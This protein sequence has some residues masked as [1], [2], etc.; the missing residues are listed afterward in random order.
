ML[1]LRAGEPVPVE[2]LVEAVWGDS[3][4]RTAHNGVQACVSRLRGLLTGAGLP[5][6]IIGRDPAGYRVL[7]DRDQVDW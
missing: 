6:G 4:P 1:P 3:P 5:A 2:R 7:V